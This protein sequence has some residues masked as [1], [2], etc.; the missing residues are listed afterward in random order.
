MFVLL[1]FVSLSL[2]LFFSG[3]SDGDSTDIIPNLLLSDSSMDFG[4][5]DIEV[6][7][8]QRL[9]IRNLKSADVTIVRLTLTNSVFAVS[10]YSTGGQAGDLQI[11]FTIGADEAEFIYV[12]FYPDA[13]T[14]FDGQL[15][16]ES[17]VASSDVQ[18]DLVDLKGTGVDFD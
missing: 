5:V 16:I 11:P 14:E 7:A 17:Q 10:G 4:Q 3:C 2:G 9:T 6:G 18:T 12:G 13:Y 15:V 1:L 8:V